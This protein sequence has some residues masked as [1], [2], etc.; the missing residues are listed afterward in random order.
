MYKNYTTKP[1][2]LNPLYAK[3]LLIM[4][5]TTVIL[6][7]TLMQVSASTFAQRITMDRHNV[8]LESVLKEIRKQT[9]YS[10]IYD[11]RSVNDV[12]HVSV[13][14]KDADLTDVL[15]RTLNGLDLAFEI[16]G[17][18]VSIVKMKTTLPVS[19]NNSAFRQLVL[20]STGCCAH[21]C[22]SLI[23]F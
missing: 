2:L 11:A 19:P 16:E 6:I 21:G 7:A 12:Q 8:S 10:F 20:I 23:S 17:K 15:K 1:W 14:V 3:I 4:R 9:G 5:L 22:A 13:S 18:I